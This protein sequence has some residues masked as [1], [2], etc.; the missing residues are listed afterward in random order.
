MRPT[1]NSNGAPQ[2][3]DPQ[4]ASHAARPPERDRL[5][6]PAQADVHV[7]VSP[8]DAPLI[9]EVSWEVCSQAGGIYTV[10]RSKAP[11]ASRKWRSGY[12]LIGPYREASAKIEFEPAA[13][14]GPVAEA[15]DEL[16]TRGVRLH[17]GNWLITGRP[18]VVLIDVH[19]VWSHV[20]EMKYYMWKDLGIS[21]PEDRETDE[22]VTFGHAVADLLQA[23]QRRM[24]GRPML[25]HFHEW[26]GACALPLLKHRKAQFP[27]VFTTHATLVGRSL[28]AANQDL[29]N[30]LGGIAPEEVAREH[31]ILHRFQIERAAAQA[32]D[33][34]TTVSGITAS[35]AEQF[36][37][38][39]PDALLPN[40]LN[41]ERFAAPHEFQ[42]LH[43]HSKEQIHEFVMGHFFPTYTFDLQKTLYVFTAGRYE[44]RNKGIDVFI[45]SLY[46]LNRR[47]KAEASGMTIVAFII[48]KAPY[49]GVNVNSLNRQA[50]FNELRDTCKSISGEMGKALFRS[51]MGG[52]LP[53]TDDLMDEYA[54]VRLLRM[55][56]A[57]T[58]SSLPSVVT[59][60]LIDEANDP[61]MKHL[62]HRG[63]NNAP[64]D[65]V[66]VIFYPDFITPTCPI[67]GMEYDHFVRGCNLGIFPS[68]YE[69]WGYTPMECIVR[70]VPAVT[71]D[72]SGFG[73][74]LMEHF[75][76][77]DANGM[78][79]ARRRRTSF[80]RTVFQVTGW[81]YQLVRMGLRDRIALRNRVEAYSEYFDWNR[82]SRYYRAA[83][84]MAFERYYPGRPI[85]PVEA[86]DS[87]SYPATVSI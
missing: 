84:R 11:S 77:H 50:M 45:E 25:G 42:N 29:Y 80:D 3:G 28:S 86:E 36:L 8:A 59:H 22:I 48:A 31:G 63:L 26:Q 10:L 16:R 65:P 53:T 58:Q 30:K 62:K 38:R 13:I 41:V 82:M 37:G 15:V 70:G 75:P 35:E 14:E 43:L 61:V 20:S 78:F 87:S 81:M 73:A 6:L 44:Y 1:G 5:R 39:R 18:Q 4:A 46:E 66:K 24:A 71:S 33:I 19:S 34:F 54:R 2:P 40:G 79:V 17:I 69:P 51:I 60:D 74:F 67:L 83:R 64:D 32:A 7:G 76:D 52:K 72:L 85:I 9:F 21:M 57:A 55:M 68:Y 27:T 56:H 12:W 47:L 23:V 49:R